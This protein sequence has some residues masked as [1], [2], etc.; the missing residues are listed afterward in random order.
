MTT[1]TSTARTSVL[2]ID[3]YDSF[4][5]NLVDEF[6]RRDCQVQVWRNDLPAPRALALAAELPA[7]RLVVLSPGPGRPA[8]A[9][10]CVELVRRAPD[11]LPILGVCL[12][13]QA[14][15]EALGGAVDRAPQIV[16]GKPAPI[17]HDGG[18]LFA[19]LPSPLIAGRYHSLVGS[20][21][22]AELAV[23]ARCGDLPMAIAHRHRPVHGVQFHP[24]SILTPRGGE[25]IDNALRLSKEV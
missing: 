5:F 25:L 20:R 8:D 2:F 21:I 19:G 4:V 22:P 16:H 11:S 3:N 24:E 7:P 13:H 10:C 12:G 18:E 1:A 23:T 6:A 15:V 9:G 14:I 17:E